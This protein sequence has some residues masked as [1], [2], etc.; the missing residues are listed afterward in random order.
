M[1][2]KTDSNLQAVLTRE[3]EVSV[4]RFDDKTR[5]IISF[6]NV[7]VDR[8]FTGL[9]IAKGTIKINPSAAVS[10]KQNKMD[11]YKVLEAESEI[12]DDTITPIDMFVNGDGSMVNGAEAPEVDEAGNLVID[13]GEEIGRAHV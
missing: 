3:S 9:I 12:A 13:Y 11:L 8:N 10:V 5:L 4:S 7:T 2:Y 1:T 6:G